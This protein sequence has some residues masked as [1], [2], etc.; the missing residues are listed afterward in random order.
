[1]LADDM[2]TDPKAYFE[3]GNAVGQESMGMIAGSG[4]GALVVMVKPT[5]LINLDDTPSTC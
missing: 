1:M 5:D 2:A 4:S 3:H